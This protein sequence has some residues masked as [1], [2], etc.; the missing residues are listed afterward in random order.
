M[1]FRGMSGSFSALMQPLEGPGQ[2][3]ALIYVNKYVGTDITTGILT[4]DRQ[5]HYNQSDSNIV[6]GRFGYNFTV[7]DFTGLK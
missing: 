6:A 1:Y 2:K 3:R 7:F 4:T 5:V